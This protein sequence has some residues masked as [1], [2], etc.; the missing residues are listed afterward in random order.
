M[1]GIYG[2]AGADLPGDRAVAALRDLMAARGPDGAGLWRGPGLVL[3]HRRL[4]VIDPAAGHQPMT[5]PDGSAI[6]YNGTLYNDDRLRADLAREGFVFRTACDTETVLAALR[7]WGVGALER[8]RGMYALA[9]FDHAA[10]RLV[11]ARDPLGIKPLYYRLGTLAGSADAGAGGGGGGVSLVCASDVRAIARH[12]GFTP[13]PDLAAVG[14]YLTT[15]RTSLGSRTLLDGISTLRPG[16]ALSF[17]LSGP[18]PALVERR[19]IVI[20]AGRADADAADLAAAVRESVA[21][22]LRSDVPTSCLLSGGLDSSIIAMLAAERDPDLFTYCAGCPEAGPE[23]GI[24]QADDFAFARLMAGVL[25]SHH[26]EVPVG[27]EVFRD[28]WPWMI[29]S[30]GLPLST[31]N[32]VAIYEVARRLRADGRIVTLSGEGAD[33]LFG[34]Y[35]AALTAASAFH[36]SHPGAGD[37]ETG[38]F[39]LD[40]AAWVPLEAKAGLMDAALWRGLESD[41]ALTE[42]YAEEFAA[43]RGPGDE[44]SLQAHLRFQRATNL[45]GLLAR[46]D[47]AS[48]LAGVE[49]RTPFAD[50]D[51]AALAEALPMPAKF[52]VEPPGTKIA[53]RAAFALPAG[54]AARPK[55]SF[56]L[57]FQ[58][59]GEDHAAILPR[60]SLIAELFT[61]AAIQAVAARPREHWRFAWPMINIALWGRAWW[62]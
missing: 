59:W 32:E 62:G 33:E 46:L 36:A 20:G 57:P 41:A 31:P 17:D 11:L 50:R 60:S 1:C 52:S 22:H 47:A 8:M 40:A 13:R 24:P 9:F 53:L 26:T 16:E 2:F 3:A 43:A 39:L 35:D 42:F 14:A 55:A 10:R 34:G 45:A 58:G 7:R 38:R 61:P 23:G 37:R 19:R 21:V 4:A 29:E 48:M 25:G 51:I 18:E 30:V 5:L 44:E 12:P 49:G 54:I 27:R 15:I 6:V 56:P 28:R